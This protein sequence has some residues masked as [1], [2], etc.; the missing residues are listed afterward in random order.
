MTEREKAIVTA[1]TGITML[2]GEGL[3]V[4]YKYLEELFGRPI[5]THE[6]PILADE[7][8]KRSSNDFVA[9]C[10]KTEPE[11]R[12]I[13][14][15]ERLP[16]DETDVLVT[17]HFLSDSELKKD[18]ITESYYVEVANRI[19]DE[20]KSY[21]DEYKIRRHLHKVIAWMPLPEPAKEAKDELH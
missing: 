6:I 1:Y 13:P 5:Y 16:E 7:I 21:S 14:V 12:W 8:K 20:W 2:Q 9:L 10:R 19:D 15:E 17:R 18:S 3:N 4:F 11:Q